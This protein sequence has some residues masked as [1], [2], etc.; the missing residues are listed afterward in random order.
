VHFAKKQADLG[1]QDFRAQ[2]SG[3]DSI[4]D[5]PC[6]YDL[7]G[8]GGVRNGARKFEGLGFKHTYL[9]LR[10]NSRPPPPPFCF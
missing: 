2:I 4:P 8:G 6:C 1:G 7:I 3:R 5:P 9:Q 10:F